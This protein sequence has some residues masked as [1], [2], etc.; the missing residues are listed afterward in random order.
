MICPYCNDEMKKGQIES[1]D[2]CVKWQPALRK[3]SFIRNIYRGD[4]EGC[5]Y[6]GEGSMLKGGRAEAYYCDHCR[7][8]IVP[9]GR[10]KE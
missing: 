1:D 6:F 2:G 5:V 3:R 9:N 7:M 8:M 10:E 4:F